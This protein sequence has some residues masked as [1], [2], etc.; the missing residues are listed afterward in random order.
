MKIRKIVTPYIVAVIFTV[1]LC[2][3][4]SHFC[5][6]LMLVQGESMEPS[7]KSGQLL[8]INKLE[9]GYER[10]DCVLFRSEALGRDVFKRIVALPGDT[11]QILCGTLYVNSEALLPYPGCPGIEDAGLAASEISVPDGCC[12]VL[13]DNFSH[14]IDSR[15]AQLGFVEIEDI[16]GTIIE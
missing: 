7:Y 15:S 16:I 3:L 8:V 13:G 5:F 10:L 1:L 14:S 6:Q 4:C 2:F 12:F 9:Q 11:V